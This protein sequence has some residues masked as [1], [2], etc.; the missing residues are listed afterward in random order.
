MK[1]V[2]GGICVRAMQRLGLGA[3]VA[4]I[5]RY[6]RHRTASLLAMGGGMFA[7]GETVQCHAEVGAER[8]L[9]GV[10][11]LEEF[12]FEGAGEEALRQILGVFVVLMPFQTDVFVNGLPVEGGY[13]FKGLIGERAIGRDSLQQR[14]ARRGKAI[15]MPELPAARQS[16]ARFRVPGTARAD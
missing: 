9:R 4:K 1:H 15:R 8:S 5:Q 10:E 13:R 12:A 16:P 3:G 2:F 11:L 14:M 6:D 7:C